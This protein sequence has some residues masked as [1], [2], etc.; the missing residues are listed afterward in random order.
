MSAM[1]AMLAMPAESIGSNF[2]KEIQKPQDA[3]LYTGFGQ[4]KW[5]QEE[6]LRV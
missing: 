2:Q 3:V 1:Q 6:H 5:L 4:H